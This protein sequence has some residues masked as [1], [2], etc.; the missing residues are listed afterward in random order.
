MRFGQ[1]RVYCTTEPPPKIS[2]I[3]EIYEP[4]S[5]ACSTATLDPLNETKDTPLNQNAPNP[6]PPPPPPPGLKSRQF[7][8]WHTMFY[9]ARHTFYF[10]S[11]P[12]SHP[13]SYPASWLSKLNAEDKHI[14]MYTHKHQTTQYSGHYCST[15]LVMR[16]A[17]LMIGIQSQTLSDFSAVEQNRYSVNVSQLILYILN[18]TGNNI[19]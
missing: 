12:I 8:P 7:R 16:E 10:P 6:P 2:T 1:S 4:I 3:G 13:A 18:V 17:L 9:I 15:Y 11:F 5:Q 14:I 19:L